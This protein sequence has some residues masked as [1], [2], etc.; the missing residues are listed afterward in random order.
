[1]LNT[2]FIITVVSLRKT[3]I[4]ISKKSSGG[5]TTGM[6]TPQNCFVKFSLS[7]LSKSNFSATLM[8]Y[9][10]MKYIEC[11]LIRG[12]LWRMCI[13]EMGKGGNE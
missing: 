1:M 7:E 5:S 8:G 13:H 3:F 4:S 2:G 9:Y 12:P 10:L 11:F 6:K